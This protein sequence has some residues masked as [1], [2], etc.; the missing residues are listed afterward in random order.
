MRKLQSMFPNPEL[1]FPKLAKLNCMASIEER[2]NKDGKITSWR[3][4]WRDNNK[5]QAR[6]LKSAQAAEHWKR[7]IEAVNGDTKRA[8]RNLLSTLSDSPRFKDIAEAHVKRL[9]NAQPFTIKT[10]NTYIRLHLHDLADMPTDQ[11]TED[12][13]IEWTRAMLGTKKSPKT[14]K[15]V[16]GF[17]HAV[18]E[19]AVRRKVRPDNPCNSDYL[20]KAD[21][22]TAGI[23]F[24]PLSDFELLITEIN[25]HYHPFFRFL[26]ETGLRVSE[27]AALTPDDFA[28]NVAVPHV[29]VSK[30]WKRQGRG[31]AVE[32]G[33]PKTM[34][35]IRTV[36][37]ARVTVERMRELILATSPGDLV[38]KMRAG[39]VITPSRLHSHVW[40]AAV[41]RAREAGMKSKPRIHDLRH[42]HA[43]IMI[44]GGT[45]LYDLADRLG[46]ESIQTTTSVYGHLVPDAL[47][48]AARIADAAFESMSEL[49]AGEVKEEEPA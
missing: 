41:R 15:N 36:S 34:K 12:D 9:I 48:K 44:A 23:E 8:Q 17:I 26:L 11:I 49:A 3:V 33:T 20:P 10:Y 32:L 42:T 13:L 21:H 30:A 16:H 1:L 38:F 37:L 4:I 35:G 45:N 25:P 2:K 19:S 31:N 39:N 40:Q 5:R 22:V 7:L 27:A 46:H 24:L 14:I 28:L 43:S 6:T 47:A 29:R 18:M